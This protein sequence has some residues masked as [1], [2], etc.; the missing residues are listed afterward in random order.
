MIQSLEGIRNAVNQAKIGVNA[1]I[2]ND[3]SGYRLVFTSEQSGKANSLRILT[4]DA[5]TTNTNASGLSQLSYDPTKTAGTGKNLSETV[6]A[7]NAELKIDGLSISA[8]TNTIT[9]AIEGVSLNLKAVSDGE[10]SQVVVASDDATLKARVNAFVNAYNTFLG[11]FKTL[12]AYD[13]ATKKTGTL[14]GD[15]GLRS[16]DLQMRRIISSSVPY[17]NQSN[18]HSLADIGISTTSTGVLKLDAT[19]LDKVIEKDPSAIG[20][21]FADRSPRT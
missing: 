13:P 18:Y 12:T 20:K 11:E 8:S 19:K 14:N 21:L 6:A 9:T 7:Q 15:A 2:I 17:L 1:S 5:D 3:G 16:I 4:T 10:K